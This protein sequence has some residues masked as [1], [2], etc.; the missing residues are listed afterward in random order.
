MRVKTAFPSPTNVSISGLGQIDSFPWDEFAVA[1]KFAGVGT[2]WTVLDYFGHQLIGMNK[3]PKGYFGNKLLFSI[4]A[5]IAGRF[6]SDLVGG[7]RLVRAA[8]LGTTANSIMHLM[9]LFS[10]PSSVNATSYLVNKAILIPLSFLI[11]GER[12]SLHQEIENKESLV[13]RET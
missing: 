2:A 1:G 6:L 9:H 8:V 4:P 12:K 13:Q 7:S 5:L 11:T 3:A 10:M